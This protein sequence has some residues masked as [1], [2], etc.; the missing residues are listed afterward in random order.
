MAKKEDSKKYRAYICVINNYTTQDIAWFDQLVTRY[1]CY[2]LEV[3]STGTPHI[4]GYMYFT[5]PRSFAAV[6]ACHPIAHWEV[7]KGTPA[8]NR[9]YCFKGEMTKEEWDDQGAAHP[10]YGTDARTFEDGDLPAQGTRSDIAV[11]A[12]AAANQATDSQLFDLAPKT[13]IQCY[14][15]LAHVRAIK[16]KKPED[17]PCEGHWFV[18]ST[19]TGKSRTA[20]EEFP[21]HFEKTHDQWWDGYN[22][23]PVVLIEEM[24]PDNDI[25]AKC[26]KRWCDRYTFP[27]KLKGKA[28]I[29]IRPT[30]IVI[31][32]N[33]TIREL[34]P[35]PN[36][37]EPLERRFKVRRFVRFPEK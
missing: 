11:L 7:A 28:P 22:D 12:E 26:L 33:W 6:K 2:G 29:Q 1:R 17:C 8:Q 9:T 24:S 5:S 10:K 13:Y 18:G 23:E 19:E 31:T 37:Y 32:S 4:Q 15:A 3:A 27:G 14:R 36:D 25:P 20:R 30:T 21:N 35:D 16:R 34:F